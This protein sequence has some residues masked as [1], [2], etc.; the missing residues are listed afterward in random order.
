MTIDSAESARL[1]SALNDAHED[2]LAA[3]RAFVDGDERKA[4]D[5]LI[6]VAIVVRDLAADL[7][8]HAGKAAK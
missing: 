3:G 5:H 2:L 8:R 7:R 6:D 1:L 4:A